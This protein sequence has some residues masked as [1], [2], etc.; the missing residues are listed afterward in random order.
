MLSIFELTARFEQAAS[1]HAQGLEE[2]NPKTA[3]KQHDILVTVE[4]ELRRRRAEGRAAILSLMRSKD[5]GVRLC[6][7][8]T[9]LNFAPDQA[10]P[11]LKEIAGGPPGVTRLTAEVTLEEWRKGNIGNEDWS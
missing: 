9:A 1:L 3:N 6:A 5:R 8:A 4:E 11:V 7:A 2:G 10:E